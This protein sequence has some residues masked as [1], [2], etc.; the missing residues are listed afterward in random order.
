MEKCINR[1]ALVALSALPPG[2]INCVCVYI[3]YCMSFPVR[4]ISGRAEDDIVITGHVHAICRHDTFGASAFFTSTASLRAFSW[5]P[6]F[7]PFYIDLCLGV[8]GGA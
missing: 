1:L 3:Q 6:S 8:S 2:V 5:F 7:V 4:N